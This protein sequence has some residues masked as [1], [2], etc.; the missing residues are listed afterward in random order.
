MSA[1]SPRVLVLG[2][3]SVPPSL[4]FHHFLPRMPNLRK[5][6][7]RSAFGTLRSTDPPITVPAWAVLFS[8]MDPGSLGIYGFRH[9]RPGTYFENYVP[10]SKTVRHPLLWEYLSRQGKRSCIIGMPP[11]YPP[12]SINGIYISDFLTPSQARDYVSPPSLTDEIERVSGGYV[13]DVLFRADDRERIGRELMEMTRKHFRVARHLWDRE[14]WDLFALHE[15]G[16]DRIHHTFWK[17]FD[18]SHPRYEENPRLRTLVEQYYSLLDHEIGQLLERVPDEVRIW[19]VSDHGSQAMQGCFCINEW[20]LAKGFLFLQG[21]RPPPGTPL[22]KVAV[23]WRRTQA[24]GS[25][26]YYARLFY[27]VQ[28]REPEGIVAPEEV[29]ALEAR[30]VEGLRAVVKPDGT[31]LGADVRSPRSLYREVRGDAPD[32][33]AYFGNVAWRSAG[34]IGH[35]SL[36]LTDNDTGP[37]DSVHSFEGVY[38]VTGTWEGVGSEG[39]QESILDV[40]P[41]LLETLGIPVPARMQGRTIRRLL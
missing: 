8:G 29:G 12:P 15:I 27:N 28:G 21:P 19:L 17:F 36:F 37:D 40:A 6:L 22:E 1:D 34:T 30:L 4:L 16:P 14:P 20:L 24:W 23:D 5:L 32:L 25:G 41:T 11:G 3:D 2:L 31:P 13:F 7:T 18:P 38:A 35:P 33:M 10:T 39:P 26:G 9:R